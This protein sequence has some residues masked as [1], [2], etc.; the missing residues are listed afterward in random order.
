MSKDGGFR[1]VF[2]ACCQVVLRDGGALD[3]HWFGLENENVEKVR[4][5][6]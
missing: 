1:D 6:G 5:E 3:L 2:L 4:I